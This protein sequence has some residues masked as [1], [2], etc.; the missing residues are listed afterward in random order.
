MGPHKWRPVIPTQRRNPVPIPLISRVVCH[1]SLREGDLSHLAFRRCFQSERK[2]AYSLMS[3]VNFG[4]SS[5]K[6]HVDCSPVAF[7][8]CIPF[9]PVICNTVWILL[10]NTV[11][12]IL[13][14]AAAWA[15]EIRGLDNV[16][17]AVMLR[18]ASAGGV[19]VNIID[20]ATCGVA[21][22]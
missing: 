8:A 1:L 12:I 15:R 5:L 21:R 10:L 22:D 3:P 18:A 16:N 17:S 6:L 19:L 11:T 20:T 2:M 4:F 7:V 14:H 13:C 9:L